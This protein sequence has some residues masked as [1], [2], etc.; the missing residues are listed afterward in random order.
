[1]N[2]RYEVCFTVYTDSSKMSST[3][4]TCYLTT[5]VEC[6]QPQQAQAM[7]EAQY[8]GRVEVHSVNRI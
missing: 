6:F 7:V 1:M 2:N 5:V 4:N 8:P 3:S